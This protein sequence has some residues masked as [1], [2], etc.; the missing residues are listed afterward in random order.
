M[1]FENLTEKNINLFC[2]KFYD[3]PQCVDIEEYYE[4]LNR[5][6]YI[7][8][9]LTRY[10][11]TNVLNER[12]ILN[13]LIILNNVYGAINLNRI[14]VFHLL[15]KLDQILPFLDILSLSQ[16]VVKGIN[17]NDIIINNIIRDKDITEKLKEI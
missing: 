3:N 6:K 16:E 13:H 15:D 4:D 2:N 8:K 5:L 7:K 17:G 1:D 11:V 14:I 12:L 9:L 10:K